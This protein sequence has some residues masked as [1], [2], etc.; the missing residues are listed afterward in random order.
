MNFQVAEEHFNNL[1]NQYSDAILR[2][3]DLCDQAVDPL[4]FVRTAGK[5]LSLGTKPIPTVIECYVY[6]YLRNFSVFV[7]IRFFFHAGSRIKQ[8]RRN[9]VIRH[10]VS[11]FLPNFRDLYIA[12]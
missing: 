1:K 2:C 4:D 12:C 10:S 6:E 5:F 7:N 3:R 11:Y 8:G 9:L